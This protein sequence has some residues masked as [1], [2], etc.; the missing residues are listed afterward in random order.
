MKILVIG[1]AILDH[2][3]YGKINRQSP[4]DSS[5]PIVD[6]E[7]EDFKLGGCLNVAAN[8]KSL[9]SN[10]IS[11]SAIVSSELGQHLHSREIETRFSYFLTKPESTLTKIRIVDMDK[12]RQIVRLDNRKNFD[13]EIVEEYMVLFN[14]VNL[15]DFDCIV[16]S[17]YNKG[18]ITKEIMKKLGTFKEPLFVDT[19]NPYLSLWNHIPNCYIKINEKEWLN[20]GDQAA[21]KSKHPIIVTKGEW[22]AELRNTQDWHDTNVFSTTPIKGE[23]IDITGSGDIFLAALVTNFMKTKNMSSAIKFA[24][25]AAG[26]GVRKFGTAEV[27]K[28]EIND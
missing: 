19:K 7:N 8:L 11:I 28:S 27:Y 9:S 4:E 5:V 10:E 6:V 2:Y 23:N 18:T 3:L 12:N 17:D 15:N 22:G 16:V 24:N 13:P 14:C 26:V 25:R 21:Q 1:D 20:S